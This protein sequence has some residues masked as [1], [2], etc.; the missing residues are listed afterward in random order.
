[1]R[2]NGEGNVLFWKRRVKFVAGEKYNYAPEKKLNNN[3][4]YGL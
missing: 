4:F 2:G 3:S 1:M